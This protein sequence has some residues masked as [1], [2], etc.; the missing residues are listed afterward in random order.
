VSPPASPPRW[1][2]LWLTGA[3]AVSLAAHLG[4][5]AAAARLEP[6]KPA[7]PEPAVVDF[8]VT[9]PP[10]PPKPAPPPPPPAPEP[11]PPPARRVAVKDLPPPPKEPPPPPP[12]NVT[13]PPDQ[14]PARAPVVTGLSLGSTV[15]GGG[16]AMQVGN[17]LYGKADEVARD[18][19]SVKPYAAEGTA[20]PRRGSSQPKLVRLSEPEY[21]PAARKAGVEGQVVLL[22]R[23]DAR[24]RVVSA[25]VVSEPGTGTGE[26]ARAALLRSEFSPALLEGEAVETEIRFT[27]NFVL[28]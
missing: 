6:R 3:V 8:E 10:P 7:R 17:T 20:P 18:P 11:T 22:L 19:R 1:R 4:G 21:P 23:I 25:R 5:L 16:V 26:A 27:Y 14:K 13:P 24:G 15:D 12:P 9:E 28:E 2:H